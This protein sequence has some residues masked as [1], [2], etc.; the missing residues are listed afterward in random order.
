MAW[1]IIGTLYPSQG[2][3]NFT[4]VS[5][6]HNKYN[7]R[8][9]NPNLYSV[10]IVVKN[11]GDALTTISKESTRA[12]TSSMLPSGT[13]EL[14]LSY[15]SNGSAYVEREEKDIA[16]T[17]P[18]PFTSPTGVLRSGQ[19][20]TVTWGSS[21]D[22]NGDV[23]TYYP[24]Y[25]YYKADVAQ[26]WLSLG[27]ST[28]RSRSLTLTTDSTMNLIEFRVRASDGSLSSGYRNSEVFNIEH[29]TAP[30]VNLTTPT[31]N[32]TLYEND[33]LPIDGSAI[34]ANPDQSVTVY[35]QI[36][37]DA[38]K[39]LATDLSQKAINFNR[40]LLFKDGKLFDGETAVSSTLTDGVAHTLKVWAQDSEGAESLIETR[41]F[42]VVPNRAPSL[43]IDVVVP[44]GNINSDKF[45]VTG[46]AYDL[47]AN[48]NVK[49]TYRI[50]ANNS[51]EVYNGP[52]GEFEFE[53]SLGQLVVGQNT[54]VV[55]VID[56]YGAKYSKTIK[57]NKNEVK[58][59][60]LKSTARYKIEPPSG[61]AKGVLLW[62]QRN[63]NLQIDVKIS[64]TLKGEAESYVPMSLENTAP[65]ETGIVEDEYFFETIEPKDN[66]ILQID[67]ERSSIGVDDA[68]TLISG[69]LE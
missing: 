16:P 35:Y 24:E 44:S 23:V 20:V 53:I 2:S 4:S 40:P 56:N 8:L 34:D 31:D 32:K 55:E 50:N 19:N 61:S 22:S 33:V 49:V 57:L 1:Q 62:V 64:M 3:T 43:T 37:N 14:A 47:D 30:T 6:D 15:Q 29:N 39:V 60:L 45:K 26:S 17:T 11:V 42:Y 66:I 48:A 63:E 58:T 18:G 7:Y 25:R 67:M 68:I 13:H 54:I 46:S 28:S 51:V 69:V 52:G 38:R 59:P 21:T 10:T 9:R 27:N 12:I 41:S 36:N 5:F 65:V